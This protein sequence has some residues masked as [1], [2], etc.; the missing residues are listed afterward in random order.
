MASRVYKLS[1]KQY[2]V[3]FVKSLLFGAIVSFHT[4]TN[5]NTNERETSEQK[6]RKADNRPHYIYFTFNYHH[7]SSGVT[8]MKLVIG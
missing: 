1:A 7:W 4:H 3:I 2:I 8:G 5:T 6:K